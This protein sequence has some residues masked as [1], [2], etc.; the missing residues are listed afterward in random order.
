M[1]RMRRPYKE[2]K[3]AVIAEFTRE[4]LVA[5]LRR[6]GGN[7]SAAARE[8]KIE[9]DWLVALARRYDIALR[10]PESTR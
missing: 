5:L 3:G 2:A 8:A 10:D 1:D 4:Y 6:H 9:R 7:A